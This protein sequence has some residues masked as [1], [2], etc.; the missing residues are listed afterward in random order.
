MSVTVIIPTR[1]QH[2]ILD[3]ALRSVASAQINKLAG[4]EIIVVNNQGDEVE[5]CNYLSSLP[6]HAAGLGLNDVKVLDFDEPFNFSA[7]NNLAVAQSSAEVLCFLNNDIEVI[8]DDWLEQ[9]VQ[10][11]LLPEV[12]C[13][14]AYLLF[15]NDTVQHGGVIVGMDTIAGHAFVGMPRSVADSHPFF[16][17]SRHC[18]AI[19]GACLAIRRALFQNLGGFDSSLAVAFNDID[20][21]LK[22]RQAGYKNVF[23]PSVKLYHDESVS[24]GGLRKSAAAK[25]RHLAEIAIMR[26][27]WNQAVEVDP[28]WSADVAQGSFA[29]VGSPRIEY[30]KTIKRRWRKEAVLTYR[31]KDID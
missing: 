31:Y 20:L 11:A 30:R 29:N 5:S 27:R 13:V 24:R 3:Q 1:N 8:T 22:A 26:S 17:K 18:T 9:L 21:C 16:R 19:T 28:Y 12:G 4:L 10:E 14:G 6:E 15:P 2:K 7:M 25:R 23:L